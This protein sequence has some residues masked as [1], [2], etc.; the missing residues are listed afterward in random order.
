MLPFLKQGSWP[1]KSWILLFWQLCYCLGFTLFWEIEKLYVLKPLRRSLIA[2][3]HPHPNHSPHSPVGPRL[4]RWCCSPTYL[5]LL[6]PPPSLGL[7][8][9]SAQD[10]PGFNKSHHLLHNTNNPLSSL[11]YLRG[12]RCCAHRYTCPLLVSS[13]AMTWSLREP[14]PA[15]ALEPWFSVCWIIPGSDFTE[16]DYGKQLAWT[17]CPYAEEAPGIFTK[18]W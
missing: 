12:K 1:W 5:T 16:H 4:F 10:P 13:G 9:S 7:F 14:N 17:D 18:G 8:L 11:S 3:C 2:G 15:F 6:F